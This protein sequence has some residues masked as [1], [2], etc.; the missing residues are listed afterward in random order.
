MNALPPIADLQ[1]KPR[2]MSGMADSLMRLQQSTELSLLLV[3]ADAVAAYQEAADLGFRK[4]GDLIR[5]LRLLVPLYRAQFLVLVRAD[6]QLESMTDLQWIRRINLGPLKSDAAMSM[7]RLYKSMFGTPLPPGR[8]THYSD[9]EALKRLVGDH[10]VD[11]VV[12]LSAAPAKVLADMKPEARHY[13]RLLRYEPVSND[14]PSPYEAVTA[15]ASDYSSL[16]SEDLTTLGVAFWL[17][18]HGP[19]DEEASERLSHL[20]EN[21][22]QIRAQLQAAGRPGWAQIPSTHWVPPPGASYAESIAERLISCQM[23]DKAPPSGR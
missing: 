5:P 21:W 1:L 19:Y 20:V 22:C 14:A 17:A 11:A 6:S 23:P 16:L 13:V 7:S 8:V 9:E 2:T 18:A 12:V 4:A 10:S 15:F 3:P